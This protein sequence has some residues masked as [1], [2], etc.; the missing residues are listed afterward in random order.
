[1]SSFVHGAEPVTALR[2]LICSDST[3]LVC[4]DD[5]AAPRLKSRTAEQRDPNCLAMACQSLHIDLRVGLTGLNIPFRGIAFGRHN[6]MFLG[7]DRGGKTIV[8][9]RTL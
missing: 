8:V 7:V 4:I 1:M 6:W 3:A 5:C 9:P 2:R